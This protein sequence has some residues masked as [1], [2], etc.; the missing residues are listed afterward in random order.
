MVSTSCTT[1]MSVWF[2]VL[3]SGSLSSFV[4]VFTNDFLDLLKQKLDR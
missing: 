1:P 4:A 2:D 3:F